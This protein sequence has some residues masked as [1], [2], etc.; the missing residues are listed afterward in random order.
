MTEELDGAV[1]LC[2]T[3]SELGEDMENTESKNFDRVVL[4]LHRKYSVPLYEEHMTLIGIEVRYRRTN[5][6]PG[7]PFWI[8]GSTTDFKH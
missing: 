6:S 3:S 1:F 8:A 7:S 2:A 4:Q 5:V